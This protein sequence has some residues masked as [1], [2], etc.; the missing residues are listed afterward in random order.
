M[1][2]SQPFVSVV[3][4]VYN[5]A[6]HL[7]ECIESVLAQ[8]Y[9]NWEYVIVDNC[10]TDDSLCIA[11]R[12]GGEDRRIRVVAEEEYLDVI[13]NWN[14]ALGHISDESRYCKVVHADDLLFPECLTRMVA[15]AEEHSS[16]GLVAAYMLFGNRVKLD[17][18]PYPSRVVPGEEVC[19]RRLLGGPDLFGSPTSVL[20][21]SEIVRSREPF[22]P[23][24]ELHADLAVC[25][26]ILREHDYGFVHQVLSYARR[27]E[28][29]LTE[30]RSGGLYTWKAAELSMLKK[31]GRRFLDPEQYER[32][33]GE[34]LDEYYRFLAKRVLR[35]T[36][37]DFWSYHRTEL[38]RVGEPLSFWKVGRTWLAFVARRLLNPESTIRGQLRT[39]FS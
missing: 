35:S 34:V 23:E 1:T 36:H 20:V 30:K 10:S 39:T 17:A 12:Y 16:V 6:A 2:V 25:F 31:H 24:D 18:L 15:V 27:H 9:E 8:E 5:G 14:R 38:E 7:E 26:E 3:T 22:Y 29:S 33:L 37:P 13:P 4:P 11:R 19:R 28:D 21:R 32:R